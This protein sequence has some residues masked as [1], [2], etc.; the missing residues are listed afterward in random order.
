MDD[1]LDT[2]SFHWRDSSTRY[3]S[4]V[5]SFSC[6]RDLDDMADVIIAT[7]AAQKAKEA[8]EHAAHSSPQ[9][10]RQSALG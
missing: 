7:K 2:I 6:I 1:L 10:K 9:T 8:I 5:P 3:Q 4:P